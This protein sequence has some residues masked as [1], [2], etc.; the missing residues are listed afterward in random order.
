MSSDALW[1]RG[2]TVVTAESETPADLWIA[3]GTIRAVGTPEALA[4]SGMP[5]DTQ[6]LDAAGCLVFP[7]FIDPHVHAHLPLPAT[8]ARSTYANTSRAALYGGTTT[9]MDFAGSG[10]EPDLPT[11]WSAWRTAAVCMA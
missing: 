6:P 9:I 11:A 8:S 7:G 5:P 3:D 10:L 4:A 1:I 2:G